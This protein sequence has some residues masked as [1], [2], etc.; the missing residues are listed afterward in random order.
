[1]K[2]S[3]LAGTALNARVTAGELLDAACGVHK[4]LFTGE[5]GVAG[6]ADTNLQVAAG[7]A[8]VEDSA[9]RASDRRLGIVGMNICFHGLKRE[10]DTN[11]PPL[12]CNQKEFLNRL[13]DSPSNLPSSNALVAAWKNT[14]RRSESRPAILAASG[15]VLRTF[16][17][18]EQESEDVRSL[19]ADAPA[20]AVIG[21]RIGNHPGW[22]AVLLG[23]F[24]AGLVPL[25]LGDHL[26]DQEIA[27][28]LEH[29]RA[30][31]CIISAPGRLALLE[32]MRRRVPD[33][34]G[35]AP[36][37][38]KL[39]SGTTCAP[40][41][42]R[43]QTCQLL[44][45]CRNIMASM[46]ISEADLN[47]GLIPFSHSYGFS[48]LLT[49]L[50]ASGVR[51]VVSEDR[52]PRAIL[53]GL[54][55]T[56]ASVFPG[57]PQLF[58][59]LAELDAVPRLS[60]LRLCVSAGALLPLAVAEQFA[61]KFRL[62]IHAFYGASECG[63]IAFD[64][65]DVPREEGFVGTTLDGVTLEDV[66][67]GA[68]PGRVAVEG[69][70]VGDGYFPMEPG[71]ETGRFVPEDLIV[72]T[73]RGLKIVGR[74]SD[75]I[76]IAGRKLNPA[77]VEE[78][79]RQCS[80]VQE[81]VVFGVPSALRG[82]EAVACVVAHPHG[83]AAGIQRFCAR[84]LSPWQVPKDVWFVSEIPTKEGGKLSRRSLAQIY[85]SRS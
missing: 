52:M 62:K 54:D 23:L 44:A 48:N 50:I 16:A 56:G 30:A 37:F 25:P 82:E 35:R 71:M 14:L 69:A 17:Q 38:L 9:A 26:A 68:E 27:R 3:A 4:L 6:S 20:G 15:E 24:S 36:E 66:I 83:D 73:P 18:I 76:N 78:K 2:L 85:L 47:Y 11:G 43:F 34:P 61:A 33:W 28:V 65:S 21:V 13:S 53:D 70:A 64:R 8:G 60:S 80:M 74:V 7:G 45:D 10:L 57:T 49:P 79:L 67:G 84:E 72:R 39:T 22:P 5:K 46:A 63:G 41:V 1:M 59:K 75:L 12:A 55:R 58:R 29:C 77:A 40:R 81:A 42:I 32:P 51:L 31:A 19:W